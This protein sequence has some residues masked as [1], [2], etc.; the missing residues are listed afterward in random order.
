MPPAP[1][2]RF[3]ASPAPAAKRSRFAPTFPIPKMPVRWC[4]APSRNL[5]GSTSSI[6]NAGIEGEGR[7][8][9][10][11]TEEQ[12]DRV[13]A[14][15]LRGVWLG[16]KYALP[17]LVK[18]GGGAVISTASIAGHHRAARLDRLQRGESRRDRDD[19]G[20]GARVWSLQHPRE[21]HLPRIHPYRDGGSRLGR[22]GIVA[23]QFVKRA[24][25]FGRMGEPEEIAQT[26]LFLASDDCKFATGAALRHRRRLDRRSSPASFRLPFLA[27]H[28][29]RNCGS[30]AMSEVQH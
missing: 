11:V 19:A 20:G 28:F 26:A 15:N 1:R 6:N 14:I 13:I 17:E 18:R 23:E 7:F 16:M 22:T 5:A 10:E 3:V 29:R 12:F 24:S 8:T 21:L 30:D 2:T 4:R 25:V 9:A 27:H